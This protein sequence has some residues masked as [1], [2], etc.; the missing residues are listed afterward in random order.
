[1]FKRLSIVFLILFIPFFIFAQGTTFSPEIL[2]LLDETVFEVVYPKVNESKFKYEKD[3]P[4]DKLPYAQRI[5]KYVPVGTAFLLDSGEIVSAAHVFGAITEKYNFG[6]YFLRDKKGNVYEVETV[7]KYA[8]NRDF[9]SIGVPSLKYSR[10]LKVS[11]DSTLNQKVFAVG[12]AL[13]EGVIIRDGLLTS[14]TPDFRDGEWDWYRFSAAASP[15]N[16]GGPLINSNGEVLGI[17]TMKSKNE[18]LNYA[19]PIKEFLDSPKDLLVIDVQAKYSI[20][21]YINY[22]KDFIVKFKLDLPKKFQ[23]VADIVH[24]KFTEETDKTVLAIKNEWENKDF[25]K[26]SNYPDILNN[27]FEAGF[28]Y[29]IGQNES[30]E[31]DLFAPS[32][33][34]SIKVGDTGVCVYGEMGGIT[35]GGFEFSSDIDYDKFFMDSKYLMDNMLRGVKQYRYLAGESIAILSMGEADYFSIYEDKYGRKWVVAQYEYEFTNAKLLVF[36][37]PTPKG[38]SFMMRIDTITQIEDSYMNDFKIF[39]EHFY[40]SYS[41]NILDWKRFDKLDRVKTN[42]MQ[43]V[44]VKSIPQGI[45]ADYNDVSLKYIN[46][47]FMWNSDSILSTAL[48]FEYVNDNLVWKIRLFNLKLDK[49]GNTF[50]T[51]QRYIKPYDLENSTKYI[52]F[53][54][55][56]IQERENFNGEIYTNGDY[57]KISRVIKGSNPNLV[58]IV[59][60]GTKD[61]ENV[62]FLKDE[63]D[64]IDNGLS[65]K[66]FRE[67]VLLDKEILSEDENIIE[68]EVASKVDK[69]EEDIVEESLSEENEIVI[70]NKDLAKDKDNKSD[71]ADEDDVVYKI[72]DNEKYDE[73]DNSK[74]YKIGESKK[75]SS[76]GVF[77]L[78]LDQEE[79]DNNIV[80]PE[81]VDNDEKIGDQE[82]I[83]ESLNNFDFGNLRPWSRKE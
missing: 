82:E 66:D 30:N 28:P 20:P 2:N 76:L 78:F 5:D 69:V 48:G 29:L 34:K 9:I 63:I 36:C 22:F 61:S 62:D 54:D 51:I 68:E 56:I 42:A 32:N 74:I 15:G 72:E 43:G 52:S 16:S 18:N 35:L 49:T 33:K 12:N 53:W 81:I 47:K 44:N 17:I 45:Y 6:S 80:E 83:K 40:N 26:S 24:K 71:V 8:S 11:F 73:K 25:Y 59:T 55:A 19:L 38:T 65:I 10:G 23:E 7:N 31:W 21:V 67:R 13:G 75:N 14:M 41:G 70:E 60:I 39:C 58:Y 79:N 46:S 27:T 50:F 77:G 3:L 64:K 37:L 57:T 1:M 4:F